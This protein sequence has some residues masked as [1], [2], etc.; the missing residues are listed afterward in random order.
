MT[1]NKP[2]TDPKSERIFIQ[3]Y[4]G[5][6]FPLLDPS[7][8][9]I[10]LEDIAHALAYTNRFNGH[11]LFPYSVA[12][13]SLLMVDIAPHGFEM[14]A[15][16][17][18]AAEAYVGDIV[19]PLKA[20]L[21]EFKSIES[22]IMKAIEDRLHRPCTPDRRRVIRD[23]DLAMLAAERNHVMAPSKEAWPSIEG[24]EPAKVIID[25]CWPEFVKANFISTYVKLAK[26]YP[27]DAFRPSGWA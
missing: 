17:H 8:K 4:T 27:L 12:Q 9:D 3:T 22:R 25:P 24:V 13:H 7:P 6:A 10:F 21:P 1:D 19:R 26:G 20:L 5:H 11:A 16:L 23:L 15:L 2:I 18:D 14:D